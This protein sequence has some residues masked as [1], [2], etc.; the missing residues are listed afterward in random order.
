MSL[1]ILLLAGFAG[2]T[3][4]AKTERR[5]DV[6]LKNVGASGEHLRVARQLPEN[7]N[8]GA[9]QYPVPQQPLSGGFGRQQQYSNTWQQYAPRQLSPGG[10]EG[11]RQASNSYEL[12]YGAGTA[13]DWSA[14][15]GGGGQQ[16]PEALNRVQLYGAAVP[17]RY[18]PGPSIPSPKDK[19][20]HGHLPNFPSCHHGGC[21]YYSN[22]NGWPLHG[23]LH[24]GFGKSAPGLNLGSGGYPGDPGKFGNKLPMH[25]C[26]SFSHQAQAKPPK[27]FG[28]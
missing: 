14:G 1:K 26:H 17:P 7:F 22:G 24:G 10:I 11:Q 23:G 12:S 3:A 8:P 9:Q 25:G 15:N 18:L 13:V 27:P 5:S 6:E 2:I 20:G 28:K 21:Q 16:R 19:F 4:G